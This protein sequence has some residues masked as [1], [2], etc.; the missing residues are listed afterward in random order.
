MQGHFANCNKV[1][2]VNGRANPRTCA[3]CG[4]GP[5]QYPSTLSLAILFKNQRRTP[6]ELTVDTLARELRLALEGLMQ[7][8]ADNITIN[9]LRQSETRADE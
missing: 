1:L 6:A 9:I 4:L 5:C 2:R 7:E 3:V 8:E